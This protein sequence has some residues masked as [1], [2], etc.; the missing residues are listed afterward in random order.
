MRVHWVI[1]QLEQMSLGTEEGSLL[2]DEGK[3]LALLGV[4]RPTLRQAAKVVAAERLIV[5]R[6]G[7]N[8]GFFA[9][10]PRAEDAVRTPAQYL[11][12]AG[13]TLRDLHSVSKALVPEI[14]ACAANCRDEALV[15]E[16]SA[17]HQRALSHDPVKASAAETVIFETSAAGI[18]AK[19]A[20][21]PIMELINQIAFTF[22]HL[23]REHKFYNKPGDR[24]QMHDLQLMLCEAVLAGDPVRARAV[25]LNRLWL[26][27]RWIE[28]H[29]SA[30]VAGIAA[31]QD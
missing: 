11:R 21:N 26:V 14:V 3:L 13:A 4:S 6:T 23:E 10:R 16:L 9:A 30:I 7:K 15:E 17:F 24:Q 25:T 27:E 22:G 31:R 29:E 19:M 5:V 20:G 1:K 8:G 18:I 2:G 28:G 12:L